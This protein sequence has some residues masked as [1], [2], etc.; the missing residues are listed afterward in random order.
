MKAK[1]LGVIATVALA[2]SQASASTIYAIHDT[3]LPFTEYSVDGTITTDGTV[4]T[5]SVA[6]IVA[7]SLTVTTSPT[8]FPPTPV[9]LTESNST[10]LLEFG[11]NLSATSTALF[12]DY[13]SSPGA[14]F[15]FEWTSGTAHAFIEYNSGNSPP[16]EDCL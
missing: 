8:T 3:E 15:D 10:A 11:N 6:N 1:V 13:T 5:L 14:F 4:G 7:W 16:S 12:F 2:V 9:T